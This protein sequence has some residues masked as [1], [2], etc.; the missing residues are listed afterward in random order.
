[1]ARTPGTRVKGGGRSLMGP[2]TVPEP[3]AGLEDRGG[4]QGIA[5]T[6]TLQVRCWCDRS[7]V[8]VPTAEVRKGRTRSCGRPRCTA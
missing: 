8:S 3:H 2:A 4:R 7:Y 5:V 1:M 6:A